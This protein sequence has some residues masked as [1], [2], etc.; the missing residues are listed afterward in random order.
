VY[1]EGHPMRIQCETILR[2]IRER[3][4]ARSGEAPSRL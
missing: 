1:P 2:Q 3:A 4:D